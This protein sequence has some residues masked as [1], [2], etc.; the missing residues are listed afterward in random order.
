MNVVTEMHQTPW[1]STMSGKLNSLSDVAIIINRCPDDVPHIHTHLAAIP[2]CLTTQLQHY[3][4]NDDNCFPF[5]LLPHQVQYHH[6]KTESVLVQWQGVIGLTEKAVLALF[7]QLWK[8]NKA[9][10]LYKDS[11]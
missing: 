8:D 6:W 2:K 7:Y 3:F 10:S 4:S 1:C 11:L 5:T 9:L